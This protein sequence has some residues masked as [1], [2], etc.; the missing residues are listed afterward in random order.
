MRETLL[1]SRLESMFVIMAFSPS[2]GGAG[3]A[4]Y[5]FGEFFTDF[6][7]VSVSLIVAFIWRLISYYTYLAAGVIIIPNWIN[8]VRKARQIKS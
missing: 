8:K 1:Y 4:E 6:M 3:F 5:V 2:P 7:P